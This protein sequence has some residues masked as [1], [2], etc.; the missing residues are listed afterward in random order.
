MLIS[1]GGHLHRYLSNYFKKEIKIP[2]IIFI[3]GILVGYFGKDI[4]L[5]IISIKFSGANEQAKVME[6]SYKTSEYFIEAK[7]KKVT[8]GLIQEKNSRLVN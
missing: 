3:K 1:S 4:K 6:Y 8:I 7:E 5:I 2:L